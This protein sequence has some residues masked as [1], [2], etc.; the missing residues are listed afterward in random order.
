MNGNTLTI[1]VTG[2]DSDRV[3]AEDAIKVLRSAISLL[4]DLDRAQG[5]GKSTEWVIVAASMKSPL[6][7][8][9][10]GEAKDE[11][12]AP[13]EYVGPMLRSLR[14]VDTDSRRPSNFN[15]RMLQSAGRLGKLLE[16]GISAISLEAPGEETYCL[17]PKL[18]IHSEKLREQR[19]RH[20]TTKTIIEGTLERIDVHGTPE[21]YIYDR[22]TGDAVRC[23]C[24]MQDAQRLGALITRRVRVFGDVKFTREHEPVSVEVDAFEAV[25]DDPPSI[26]DLHKKHISITSDRPSEEYIRDLRNG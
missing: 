1:R 20:Y 21:F 14:M 25:I 3:V 26:T 7:F 10:R 15:D 2:R 23:F 8:T 13:R 18:K 22:L 6:S 19:P 12:V 11:S 17:T 4:E 9:I 24:D 16:N 5:A